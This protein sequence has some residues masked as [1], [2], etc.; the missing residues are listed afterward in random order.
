MRVEL[1]RC[2]ETE[3]ERQGIERRTGISLMTKLKTVGE[4]KKERRA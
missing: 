4:K 1:S 3:K 2:E